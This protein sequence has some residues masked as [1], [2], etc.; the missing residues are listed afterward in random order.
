MKY[1]RIRIVI[2]KVLGSIYYVWCLLEIKVNF[3][4]VA[5]VLYVAFFF[6]PRMKF[7]LH[8]EFESVVCSSFLH[9]QQLLVIIIINLIFLTT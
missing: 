1:L 7:I 4:V 6:L 3:A 9:F 2:D 5:V 8:F